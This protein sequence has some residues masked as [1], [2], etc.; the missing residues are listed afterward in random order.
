VK[1]EAKY[2]EGFTSWKREDGPSVVRYYVGKGYQEAYS[3]FPRMPAKDFQA[4]TKRL[5][6]N[7]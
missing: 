1:G 5:L 3:H 7:E 6:E 2:Q 4:M